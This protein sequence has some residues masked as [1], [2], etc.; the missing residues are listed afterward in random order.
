[1]SHPSP[2]YCPAG[3]RGPCQ[4][5]PR[6]LVAYLG[7]WQPVCRYHLRDFYDLPRRPYARE[8]AWTSTR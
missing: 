3:Q 8:L 4:H 6:K 5:P 1:M 2:D 7:R